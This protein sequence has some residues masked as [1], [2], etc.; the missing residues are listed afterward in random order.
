MALTEGAAAGT[1]TV[2]LAAQPASDVTVTVSSGDSGAVTASPATLTFTRTGTKI[3]S[4]A[5]TVTLT[6]VDDTDTTDESV[7]ITHTAAGGG[8]NGR[9]ATLTATVSDEAILAV[10]GISD[11]GATLTISNHGGVAWW[12]KD[13]SGITSCTSVGAGTTTASPTWPGR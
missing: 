2:R 5:Q 1:Y 9:S 7:T 3:W 13:T 4:T 11:T 6:P 12:Y 8:Y 10:S